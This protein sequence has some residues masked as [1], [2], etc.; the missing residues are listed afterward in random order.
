MRSNKSSDLPWFLFLSGLR[1]N[2]LYHDL[3]VLYPKY[4]PNWTTFQHFHCKNSRLSY[5]PAETHRIASFRVLIPYVLP[6]REYS[7]QQPKKHLQSVNH[8]LLSYLKP[9]ITKKSTL[10]TVPPCFSL[11]CFFDLVSY[12]FPLC[13]KCPLNAGVLFSPR[14]QHTPLISQ[15]L[16]LSL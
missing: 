1:F 10:A 16:H 4:I 11:C 15:S 2:T 12:H 7:I 8:M 3:V 5:S 6:Q 9:P 13:P 14:A